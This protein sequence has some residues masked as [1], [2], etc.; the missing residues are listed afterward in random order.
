[1]TAQKDTDK[2][3]IL[4]VDDIPRNLQVLGHILKEENYNISVATTGEAALEMMEH[5]NPDLILLDIM[6]PGMNGYD[7]C[8]KL[9]GKDE[10]K[11]IPIIFLTAKTDSDDI[12]KGLKLGAVDYVTKPFNGI[13]LLTRVRTHVQLR[14]SQKQL[15]ELNA[16]KDKFFSIIAHDLKGPIAAVQ[17]STEFIVDSY[18]DFEKEVFL[19]LLKDLNVSSKNL[20]RLL[21]NLLSWARAQ[22]GRLSYNPEP[23]QLKHISQNVLELLEQTAKSK[24]IDL[25]NDIP[26]NLTVFADEQMIHTVFRNLVNNAIKYTKPGGCITL[27]AEQKNKNIMVSVKDTGIGIPTEHID[28]LFRIDEEYT[29]LGTNEERGTGLGLIL[30]K[31]FIEVNKGQIDVTSELE[32][33]TQFTFT[34]PSKEAESA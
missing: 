4:I 13:E 7:V 16:T 19:D 34:L 18:D 26:D 12:I 6:L 21:Q 25:V 20:M 28:K 5:I 1:M 3:L 9:K 30:C 15:K 33:G 23:F 32:K 31:S 11:D 14:L 24:E 10:T 2:P 17:Q 8:A 29:T 22:T 27:S